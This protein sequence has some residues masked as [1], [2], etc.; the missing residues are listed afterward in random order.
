MVRRKVV[1]LIAGV[2]LALPVTLLSAIRPA[3]TLAYAVPGSPVAATRASTPEILVEWV[4]RIDDLVACRTAA[5]D[6]RRMQHQYP[7]RVRFVAYAVG[8]D[9]ELVRSFLRRERLGHV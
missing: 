7:S 8:T 6:M 3:P 5:P 9:A 4:I 1:P 2:A